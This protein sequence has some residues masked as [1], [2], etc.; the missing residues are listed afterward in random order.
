MAEVRIGAGISCS[1]GRLGG[2]GGRPE[3]LPH[4]QTVG[5]QLPLS[6]NLKVNLSSSQPR[7]QHA[8]CAHL[9]LTA[10]TALSPRAL[11]LPSDKGALMMRPG[12][13]R[14]CRASLGA[15]LDPSPCMP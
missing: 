1:Q 8:T 15:T 3:T 14:A 2:E 4:A 7:D 11:T 10:V 13:T 5:D 9:N 12:C 6:C